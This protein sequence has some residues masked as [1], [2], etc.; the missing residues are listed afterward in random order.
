MILSRA[1]K[2]SPRQQ[3]SRQNHQDFGGAKRFNILDSYHS[4][5]KL[6]NLINA[7]SSASLGTHVLLANQAS[8]QSLEPRD[9]GTDMLPGTKSYSQ[10]SS[11]PQRVPTV[12]EQGKILSEYID[13]KKYTSSN[14]KAS[15][16]LQL[17]RSES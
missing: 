10:L 9:T 6:P 7:D 15:R 1:R 16:L 4:S 14:K 17:Q 3:R 11:V 13:A 12:F 8:Y 2:V 5:S